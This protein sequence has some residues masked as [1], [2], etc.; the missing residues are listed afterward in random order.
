MVTTILLW[1]VTLCSLVHTYRRFG[2]KLHGVTCRQT[3]NVICTY[4]YDIQAAILNIAL[5]Q[6]ML[7]VHKESNVPNST[8]IVGWQQGQTY[9]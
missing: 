8:K 1:H 2:A 6:D 7:L 9:C 3:A 4:P 5:Q